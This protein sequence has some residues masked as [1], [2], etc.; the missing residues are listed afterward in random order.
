MIRCPGTTQRQ[1]RI[2]TISK[3]LEQMQQMDTKF[4]LENTLACAIS[5]WFGTG[6]V[7]LKK[8]PE[9]FHDAIWS[10]GAI[11]WRQIFNGKISRHWLVHQGHIKRQRED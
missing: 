4:K 8:Y 6:H 3:V 11:G 2:K 5:E 1:W 10:Q 9:K 7:S